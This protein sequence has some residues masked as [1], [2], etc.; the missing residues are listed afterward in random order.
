MLRFTRKQFLI[1]AASSAAIAAIGGCEQLPQES[2]G[3]LVNG[4]GEQVKT[5][6]T[7]CRYCGIGCG[8]LVEVADG[9]IMSVQAD[10]ESTVNNGVFCVKGYYLADMLKAKSRVTKPLIKKEGQFV[11]AS[12]D[13]ALDL[14]ANKFM[15][16]KRQHGADALAFYGSG[17]CSIDESYI[18]NKLY[19]GFIGT[20]NV[21]GNPRT[22]MA[23]AVA[24]YM[25]TFGKDEPMGTYDDIDKADVFFFIG[26]NPAEA[27]PVLWVKILERRYENPNIK[28]IVADPRETRSTEYAD[29]KLIFKPG[30]DLALL[31]S[32][33]YVIVKENLIDK[34]FIEK[35]TNFMMGDDAKTWEDY[36][37]FLED[38]QPDKVAAIVGVPADQIIEAARLFADPSKETI[39]MWTMGIN[40]RTRGVWANNLIHNLHLITGKLCR[41]GSTPFSLTGQPSACGSVREVG[42]LSHL[43]PSGRQI[44]N[45]KHRQEI[46]DIWDIPVENIQPSPGKAMMKMFQATVD[47]D[48]KALWV[49]TTNPGHSLPNVNKYRAGMEKC[50]LVVSEGFHPTRTTELAD[51]I[52]PTAVWCE[53]EGIYGNAE[54]RTQHMEKAIEPPGEA[55]SDTWALLEIAKRMGYGEHFQYSSL[56]DIY[57]EYRRCSIGTGYDLAPLERLRQERGVRWPVVGDGW[58]EEGSIRYAYPYDPYVSAEEGIK[59]YGKPDGRAVIFMRPQADPAE[60]P[61]A[62]FPFYLTTG[63]LLEQ[64]HTMTMTG[65]VEELNQI[66]EV[67]DGEVGWFVEMHP[68]DAEQL[69]LNHGSKVKLI[70]P[71]GQIVSKVNIGGRGKPQQGLLYT[72]FHDDHVERLANIL[73]SDAVDAASQQPEYKLS[74]CRVE[75]L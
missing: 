50:F 61:N 63:R 37:A 46:A 68:A 72:N 45:E 17:Q 20:N 71:R 4:T 25:T 14:I 29:M 21:D 26:A 7:V 9:R 38:Y 22:C 44:A 1:A 11:E 69:G 74:I 23:S 41:P 62:D 28:I 64:W 30:M 3:G 39:S 6:K 5:C 36:V 52:L 24:G 13:E 59:F 35:H 19:K 48:I 15:E 66:A 70:S 34:S 12:W 18:Y 65:N 75:K 40:Q 2:A 47:G 73:V 49:M 42:A 53:K 16:I 57:E 31:N 67:V 43:L 54:R 10:P 27:H 33:A 55:K 8:A 56:D 51:V 58:G 32:M 60:V